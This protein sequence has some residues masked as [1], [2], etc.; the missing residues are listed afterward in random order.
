MT[1]DDNQVLHRLWNVQ[2]DGTFRWH[3]VTMLVAFVIDSAGTLQKTSVL[4]PSCWL[5]T[6]SGKDSEI[7]YMDKLQEVK[8][9]HYQHLYPFFTDIILAVAKEQS[10]IG[11]NE[12]KKSI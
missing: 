12:I 9:V 7:K 8:E 3:M 1:F 10:S 4:K 6:P 11:T 2:I 5:Q